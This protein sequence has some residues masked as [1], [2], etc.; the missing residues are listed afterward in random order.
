MAIT[1]MT[2]LSLVCLVHRHCEVQQACT[3]TNM[4]MINLSGIKSIIQL[5]YF[6]PSFDKS[7]VVQ[8]HLISNE[9]QQWAKKSGDLKNTCGFRILRQSLVRLQKA[10]MYNKYI[11]RNVNF[12]ITI[13]NRVLILFVKI[14]LMNEHLFCRYFVRVSVGQA[15]KDI[16]V[17]VFTSC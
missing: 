4:M 11:Y 5:Q 13:Y 3:T 15:T 10:K 16:N 9:G 8:P 2:K 14:C 6:L 7:N 12:Q 17:K 1:A